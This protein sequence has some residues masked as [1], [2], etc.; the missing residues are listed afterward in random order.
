MI[1][2]IGNRWRERERCVRW[3]EQ[4][5]RKQMLLFQ[6]LTSEI[7]SSLSLSLPV[8]FSRMQ[9][10]HRNELALGHKYSLPSLLIVIS[11]S[12][13]LL[14]TLP[15]TPFPFSINVARHQSLFPLLSFQ[16]GGLIMKNYSI[17]P[18]LPQFYA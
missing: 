15:L 11:I 12:L 1:K 10:R 3:G 9:V 4:K 17:I 8:C 5:T 13:S 16:H 6:L 18:S 14:M 7:S 2:G